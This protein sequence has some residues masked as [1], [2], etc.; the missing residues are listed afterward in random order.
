[1]A[2]KDSQVQMSFSE[3]VNDP[4]SYLNRELST[5]KFQRRILFE[6]QN[7]DNPLLERVRFLGILG[8]VLDEF[9]MVRVGGL[10][11]AQDGSKEQFYFVESPT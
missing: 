11:M 9:F 5:L 3:L 6:A 2:E 8:S 4:M 1:M 7:K 10:T